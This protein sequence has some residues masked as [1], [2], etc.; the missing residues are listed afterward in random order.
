MIKKG[1]K[2]PRTSYPAG[3]G[4]RRNIPSRRRTPRDAIKRE[5]SGE[6]G[7]GGEYLGKHP[8]NRIP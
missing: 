2:A 1:V 5:K 8:E 6:V 7:V 4:R 3:R